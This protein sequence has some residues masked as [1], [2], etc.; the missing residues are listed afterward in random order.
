MPNCVKCG[1]PLPD[2]AK[3][4][5]V[6]GSPVP[7]APADESVVIGECVDD[8][9]GAENAAAP[10]QESPSAGWYQS[11]DSEEPSS[12]QPPPVYVK[13]KPAI[14]SIGDFYRKAL[15]VLLKK[16]VKLWG[17]SLLYA[18]IA[19]LITSLG[20]VIPLISIPL[21][22]LIGLGFRSVLL[23]GYH[24]K[25]VHTEQ[26]FSAFRKDEITRNAAGMCW[27]ELWTLIWSFVPVMNVIKAYSYSFT[28]YILLTD[29][30]IS[31]TEALRKSMRMTDGYK[32]KMFGADV[33]VVVG[34]GIAALVLLLL[35]RIPYLGFLFLIAL[36]L[37]YLAALLFLPLFM[38]LLRTAFFE[39][40]STVHTEE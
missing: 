27:M 26:L 9:P 38:G 6:C 15:S 1:N 13:V 37:L 14:G 8:A 39:E 30:D 25:E 17:L 21:V 7:A 2:E 31:A 34:L 12:P 28:P 18:L 16:P 5:P 33:L 36:F 35:G 19:S 29:K 3:F 40:I 23:N 10:Q 11:A 20:S 22:L 24:E 4:C 32:G